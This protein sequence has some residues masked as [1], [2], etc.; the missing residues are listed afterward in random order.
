L[1]HVLLLT[2]VLL[3]AIIGGFCLLFITA[4][5][6]LVVLVYG[7]QYVGCGSVV[8]LAALAILAHALGTVAGNGLWAM[9]QPQAHLAADSAMLLVTL[10]VAMLAIGPLG[11]LGAAMATL[12]GAVAGALVRTTSLLRRMR[13]LVDKEG[14]S[15]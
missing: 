9:E 2:G 12:A 15:S 8:S 4:G 3:G 7:S 14:V 5:D 11:A 1:R 10:A 6:R 13:L